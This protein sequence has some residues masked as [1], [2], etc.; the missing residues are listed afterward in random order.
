[1]LFLFRL[2][3]NRFSLNPKLELSVGIK[4]GVEGIGVT[5]GFIGSYYLKLVVL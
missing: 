3:V 4:E 5:G 2:R 1:M